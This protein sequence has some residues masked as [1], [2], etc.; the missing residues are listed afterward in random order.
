MKKNRGTFLHWNIWKF[1]YYFKK[2]AIPRPTEETFVSLDFS[3]KRWKRFRKVRRELNFCSR[4]KVFLGTKTGFTLRHPKK[5]RDVEHR[6][7]MSPTTI[8]GYGG[9]T[10]GR[11]YPTSDS[12]D[13]DKGLFSFLAPFGNILIF[14][15]GFLLDFLSSYMS[16]RCIF[17]D[18]HAQWFLSCPHRCIYS[19]PRHKA[20]LNS[21]VKHSNSSG[22]LG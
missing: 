6:K 13:H 14:D 21:Y 22:S 19:R 20:R 18:Q 11:G 2:T 5:F 1:N 15:K 3:K 9:L 4:F 7:M 16:F 17:S 8:T 12:A 10:I